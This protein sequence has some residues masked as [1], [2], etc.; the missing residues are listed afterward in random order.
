LSLVDVV[1]GTPE[2][3]ERM[4]LLAVHLEKALITS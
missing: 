4:L 3:Y 2:A 1:D